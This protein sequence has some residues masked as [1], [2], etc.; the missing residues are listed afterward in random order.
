[1]YTQLLVDFNDG[2]NKH[3]SELNVRIVN[4]WEIQEIG[5]GTDK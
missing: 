3:M 4:I 2:M 1:M 5:L